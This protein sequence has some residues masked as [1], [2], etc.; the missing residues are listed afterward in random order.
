MPHETF[1]T[2]QVTDKTTI[3]VVQGTILE[4]EPSDPAKAAIINNSNPTC[5]A[6]FILGTNILEQQ[7]QQAGGERL[8]AARLELPTEGENTRCQVGDAKISGP[9]KFGRLPTHYVIDAVGPN[10]IEYDFD[11]YE[12]VDELL[13][14][15]YGSAL[16]RAKEKGLTEVATSLIST[17][18]RG[19][20]GLKQV[21]ALSFSALGYWVSVNLSDN[22][23]MCDLL[24]HPPTLLILFSVDPV[25]GE[26]RH[27]HYQGSY[28]RANRQ[29]S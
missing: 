22:F 18:T 28:L 14:S 29:G 8:L 11:E 5:I 9:N 13:M 6:D 1:A 17:D 10:Y 7:V 19:K 20:R 4:F 26:P 27:G 3:F 15:A 25:P 12:D 2:F 24:L 23:I 21:L 16:E